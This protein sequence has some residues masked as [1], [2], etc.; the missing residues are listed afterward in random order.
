LNTIIFGSLA[1]ISLYIF[2]KLSK[3]KASSKQL[4]RD[5][6]IN[7]FK[8]ESSNQENIIEGE[9]EEIKDDDYEK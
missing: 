6:R 9:S 5:N 8:S 3:Y 1:I 7:W 4:N 2:F